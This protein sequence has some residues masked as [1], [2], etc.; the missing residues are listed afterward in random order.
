MINRI[1]ISLKQAKN[2]GSSI[3]NKECRREVKSFKNSEN[4]NGIQISTVLV[5]AVILL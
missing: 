5:Y 1:D 2:K 4:K 3:Y